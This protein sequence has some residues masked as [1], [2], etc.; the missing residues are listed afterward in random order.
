MIA[1]GLQLAGLLINTI[2][3][4]LLVLPKQAVN[5]E[6]RWADKPVTVLT[7]PRAWW[8]GFVLLLIGFVVQMVAA[9]V[10]IWLQ[11]V[12]VR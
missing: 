6:F 1:N 8:W 2:G 5:R 4:I 12:T 10:T 3:A 9:L 7:R 11:I